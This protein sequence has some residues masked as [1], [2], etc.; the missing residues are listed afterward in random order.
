M[1]QKELVFGSSPVGSI[2]TLI[3]AGSAKSNNTGDVGAAIGGEDLWLVKVNTAT[4]ALQS[5]KV[6][7]VE[8]R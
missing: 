2:N 3:A 7:E 1:K 4:G 5:Q 8:C 6:W